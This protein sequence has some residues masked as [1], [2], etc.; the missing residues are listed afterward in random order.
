MRKLLLTLVLF[1][2]VLLQ[3]NAQCTTANQTITEDFNAAT[4]PACWTLTSSAAHTFSRIYLN[5]FGSSPGRFV[6]PRAVNAK[7][8]LTFWAANTTNSQAGNGVVTIGALSAPTNWASF[9]PIET[10][11]IVPTISGGSIIAIQYTVDLSSYTGT[12]E[13]I[14][15]SMP[16]SPSRTVYFD[17]FNY[18]SA[19]FATTVSAIGQDITLQLDSTG[20]T[21][22]TT[23]TID[24]GSA[25]DCDPPTLTLSATYFDCANE[26]A[27]T[28]ILTATNNQGMIARDTVTVTVLPAIAE[29]TVTAAQTTICTGTGTTINMASSKLGIR[30]Y[31]RED[32]T[33]QY[34]NGGNR[35]GTGGPLT[36]NT[37]PISA[38]NTYHIYAEAAPP[39]SYGLDFDGTNDRVT[40]GVSLG[41]TTTFTIEAYIYPRATGYKRIMSSYSG[42]GSVL[43]GE[44]IIDTYNPTDNG[45]GLRILLAGPGN[46][47]YNITTP[48]ALTLNAWN[49]IAATFDA[50]V[51]RLYVDGTQVASG[52][53]PF[54]TLPGASK[55]FILGEDANQATA[56]F[57]NG[58]MDD[59]RFWNT[60]RT[61]NEI[62]TYRHSC[63]TS[64]YT[65]LITYYDMEEAA[66]TILYDFM[67]TSNGTMV[68][69]DPATDWVAGGMECHVI[70]LASCTKELAQ[71]V[72]ITVGDNA[73]PVAN[74]ATLPNITGQCEVTSVTAPTAT[75]ACMGTITGTHTVTLPITAH[76][77]IVWTYDD[78]NGNTSTQVQNVVISDNVAPVGNL[79]G[80]P[81]LSSTCII[82]SLTAPTA[83]DNCEGTITGTH[84]VTLPIIAST[85]IVWTYNASL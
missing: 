18:E 28:V 56:E 75:D 24:N 74:L 14:G 33:N 68:N 6:M 85:T 21:T 37:G 34:V 19:C 12:N 43:A 72:T 84:S 13:Y 78:G 10:L 26:G 36:F 47:N 42:A 77:T 57:F 31:L 69:M 49:H 70:G 23:D 62:E 39:R 50:G 76:T 32:A 40:T 55:A 71:T 15:F 59:V 20:Y 67:A 25:S 61:Q 58:R 35:I 22:I 5:T 3:A 44:V 27:N 60:A 38:T 51:V 80:L 53:A 30:Y 46:V 9:E 7:G 54:S 11:V 81:T 17:N 65:G 52:T 1:G 45:R 41:N 8:I 63:L 73:A 29:E 48:N 64:P 16:A 83:S 4:F 82:T 79:G 2:T 66:G